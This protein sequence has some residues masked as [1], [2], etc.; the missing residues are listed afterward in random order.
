MAFTARTE[1]Y[2][3]L[4]SLSSP[5]NITV[6]KPTGTVDGDILFCWIAYVTETI[7]SVPSG[8][9]SLA[10]KAGASTY[11]RL[12]YKIASS[13]PANY[14]WSL[15][16]STRI[17]AVCSCYTSGDFNAADPID[18]VSNTLYETSNTICRAA[19]MNVA[20]AN[21]PLVFW[22]GCYSSATRVFA[23]P[24]VPTTDWVEDDDAGSSTSRYWTE[25]C[26]MIWGGSGATGNMD[27]TI[28]F[29]ITN[30][31]AFAV[32]L[33]P[34]A[35]GW[36]GKIAGVTNPAKIMGVSV[37]NIAKVKGVA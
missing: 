6:T 22:A 27:A 24:S 8:W 14:T 3:D 15:T 30:K 18:V 7:D 21:S 19:S 12:Y 10:Y 23:K 9:T 25:I 20:S 4:A 28:D 33:K 5:Y 32:A 34:A 11:W 16:G 13:E 2:V 17:R 31:H 1:T 37:A 29:T 26:S 35:S 36:T